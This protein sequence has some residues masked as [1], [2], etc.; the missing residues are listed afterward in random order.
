MAGKMTGKLKKES[1][2]S[3]V[4][5]RGTRRR[6]VGILEGSHGALAPCHHV[7]TASSLISVST[8]VDGGRNDGEG[9]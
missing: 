6:S 3:R 5:Q 7:R 2:E 4:L 1:R 9:S 8:V